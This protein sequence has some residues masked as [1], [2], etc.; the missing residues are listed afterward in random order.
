MLDQEFYLIPIIYEICI[1]ILISWIVFKNKY[2]VLKEDYNFYYVYVF[3][4]LCFTVAEVFTLINCKNYGN[5][6]II[7]HI[8]NMSLMVT[9]LK[10]LLYL[11]N[12]EDFVV[13]L[14]YYTLE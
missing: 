3:F 13:I 1:F 8:I 9:Y 6:N 4:Q 11:K 7:L 5:F 14:N 2:E 10:Y 12:K